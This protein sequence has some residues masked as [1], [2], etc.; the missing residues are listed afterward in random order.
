MKQDINNS[1]KRRL[2]NAVFII[3]LCMS[4]SISLMNYILGLKTLD[5]LLNVACCV[6][7]VGLYIAYKI[8]GDMESVSL[9]V[10]IFLSFIFLPV[11]WIISGGTYSG[12]PYYIIIDAGIIAILMTGLQR[13]IMLMLYA[14]VVGG[15]IVFEYHRPDIVYAGYDSQMVRYIDLAFGLFICLF[16]IAALIAV[17]YDSYM[18]EL[19]KTKEYQAVLEEK[20]MEIEA[21][22]K[23]LEKLSI[24]DYPTGAYNKRFITSCLRE[25]IKV[26]HENQ[27]KLTI[28]MIDVDDF[29][30]INDTHGHLYGDYVL[31]RIASTIKSN[32][33]QS[34]IIGRFGGD[35]FIIILRD[36]DREEGYAML[37]HIRQKVFEMEWESDMKVTISGA[38]IE[39][40]SNE[41]TSLLYKVDRL[42]YRAKHNSK[43]M[44]ETS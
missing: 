20:N 25:E 32:I 4:F 17:L 3:G 12:M 7:T 13:K 26:S 33:R 43:N 35:E 41:M 44:I 18:D 21:K 16:S 24:T 37:E 5:I 15:L 1:L 40:G 39:A 27:N 23:M 30:S 22:N 10:A 36:T 29:K 42:L 31:E 11:M 8:T 2:L 34:D 28:A 6:I 9:V 38:V 14:L 19:R